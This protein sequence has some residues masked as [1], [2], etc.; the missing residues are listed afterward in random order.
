MSYSR[1]QEDHKRLKK[2]ASTNKY[3]AAYYS[4]YKKRFVRVYLSKNCDSSYWK[5]YS[6]K[7]VR[8]AADVCSGNAYRKV[9]D[10]WWTIL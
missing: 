10:Y 1:K 5:R 2:L 4:N 8:K 6:N 9:F 3:A 7:K